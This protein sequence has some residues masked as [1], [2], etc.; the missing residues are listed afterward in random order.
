MRKSSYKDHQVLILSMRFSLI[1]E[2]H[3]TTHFLKLNMYTMFDLNLMTT[4]GERRASFDWSIRRFSQ[5][6]K[7]WDYN[8]KD[9]KVIRFIVSIFANKMN[10]LF[11]K[12][13]FI[14]NF[15]LSI[16]FLWHT[17]HELWQVGFKCVL[18]T[19]HYKLPLS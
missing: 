17:W 16:K 10:M 9:Y 8:Y 4:K 13:K 18:Y 1:H 15:M 14:L 19:L 12:N 7:G 6:L 5:F 2:V 11:L 3:P